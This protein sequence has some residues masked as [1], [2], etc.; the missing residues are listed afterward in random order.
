MA[1]AAATEVH[2]L[3]MLEMIDDWSEELCEF[4]AGSVRVPSVTGDEQQ[5]GERVSAWL[6]DHEFETYTRTIDPRLK[7]RLGGF[8]AEHD[9]ERRPNVFGWLRSSRAGD[10][11]PLVLNTHQD[12][13]TPGAREAWSYDPWGGERIGG[14]IRGRGATD[15]KASIGAA[16]FA[17]RA[18]AQSGIE[19][20]CD[21]RSPCVVAEESGGL[22]TLSALEAEPTPGSGDR[23]RAPANASRPRPALAACT[24]R[25]ESKGNPLTP[26]PPGWACRRWT[27]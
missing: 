11:P 6:R 3:R 5:F 27:R 13:V 16:L 7:E 4:V 19:L 14:H 23:A 22:G 21:V 10:R 12:V 2:E 15:M 24:S 9:L 25:S 18:A 8:D 17:L 20:H 26:P 1:E